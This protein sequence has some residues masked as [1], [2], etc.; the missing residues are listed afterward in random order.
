MKRR[1]RSAS[2]LIIDDV[3][4]IAGKERVQEELFH[5]FNTLIDGGGQIV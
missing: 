4:F 1:F 3:Q 2:L 5:T